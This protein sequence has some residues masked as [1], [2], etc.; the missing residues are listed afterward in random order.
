MLPLPE[1]KSPDL[2]VLPSD[3][4]AFAKHLPAAGDAKVCRS[5]TGYT[6]SA[7]SLLD[8]MVLPAD[9]AAF[10][11]LPPAD[12]GAKVRMLCRSVWKILIGCI[13]ASRMDSLMH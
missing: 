10:A 1:G 6:Q 11:K 8:V 3:L 2:L 5:L 9:L 4:A 13:S 12:G 7:A